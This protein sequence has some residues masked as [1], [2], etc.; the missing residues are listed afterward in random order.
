MSRMKCELL[1]MEGA[2]N[3]RD[4]GGYPGA[5]GRSLRKRR[6][7]RA[8]SLSGL[9]EKGKEDM[10]ALGIDCVVDLRSTREVTVA[11]DVLPEG[12]GIDR[13]HVPMLD[14]IQSNIIS[15]DYS[16]FPTSMPEMYRGLLDGGRDD[17]L[18]V[19]RVFANPRYNTVLFHCTA[20]KDRTGITAMLLLLLAGVDEADV[21]EDYSWSERLI[22]PLE[23]AESDPNIPPYVFSSKPENMQEAIGHLSQCYGSARDYLAKAGLTTEEQEQITAKLLDR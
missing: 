22:A 13:Y 19:F 9:T 2:F 16:T 18:K 14:Y 8:G 20:G 7:I 3:V 23:G 17:L 6:F 11:P 21:V 4:L 5:R 10:L 12:A 1:P 15:G